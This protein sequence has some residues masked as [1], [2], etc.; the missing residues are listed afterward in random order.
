MI[1]A[2]TFT[3]I[4]MFSAFQEQE[5]PE[6]GDD[7]VCKQWCSP[8]GG[9]HEAPDGMTVVQCKGGGGESCAK[10]GSECGDEHR[11]SC[12]EYCRKQCCSCCSL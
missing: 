12:T 3:V 10:M 4:L 9:R 8:D 5:P 2:L 1:K 11:T 7:A 6:H